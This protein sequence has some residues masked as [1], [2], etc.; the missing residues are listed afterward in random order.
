MIMSLSCF[1]ENPSLTFHSTQDKDQNTWL[2]TL[3]DPVQGFPTQHQPG[4]TLIH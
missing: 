4:E 3:Q 2:Q 1:N